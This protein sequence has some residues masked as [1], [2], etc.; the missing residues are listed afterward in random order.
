MARI[1]D[2]CGEEFKRGLSVKALHKGINP[3]KRKIFV[4]DK[5]EYILKHLVLAYRRKKPV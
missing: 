3:W 4:C 1:C 2:I 5:C